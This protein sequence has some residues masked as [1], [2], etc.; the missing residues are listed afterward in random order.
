MESIIKEKIME[1]LDEN[2]VIG[3]TQHRFRKR[4]SYLTSL[5]DLLESAADAF[6]QGKQFAVAYLDFS[7][8]FDEE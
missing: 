2:N 1:F 6:D 7:K 3:S 8:A 5:L 4:H